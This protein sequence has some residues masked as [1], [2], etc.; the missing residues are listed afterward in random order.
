MSARSTLNPPSPLLRQGLGRLRR[1]GARRSTKRSGLTLI[2]MMV[3]LVILGL[4]MTWI[5][6]RIDYLLPEHEVRA[7]GRK[8]AALVRLARS[9]AV[10]QGV[11]HQIEYDLSRHEYSILV[12]DVENEEERIELDNLDLDDGEAVAEFIS[13]VRPPVWSDV[14]HEKLPGDVQFMDVQTASDN[15]VTSGTLRIELSPYGSLTPH[16]VHL[17]HADDDEHKFTVTFNGLTADA[18]FEP[19]YEHLPATEVDDG[20]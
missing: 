1:A 12:P 8:I 18:D 5:T 17:K 15:Y 16:A 7:G 14:F 19:G 11:M 4:M 6:T 10:A 9:Y 20:D 13:P 2:E 3:V